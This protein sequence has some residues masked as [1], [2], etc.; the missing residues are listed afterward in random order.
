MRFISVEDI[1]Q[2]QYLGRTV[3]SSNGTVLLSSGV[4][5][6][7][8][9]INTLKRIGV[10]M[11]YI[12]DTDFEDIQMDEVLSESTKGQVFR[13]MNELH[14][15][16]RSGKE[17]STKKVFG[18]VDALLN[19][20]L[21]HKDVLLQLT[22]IRTADNAQ[23][24]HAVNVCLISSMIGLNMGLGFSQ[25]K[26]LAVGA[27]LHD[28]GK[29]IPLPEGADEDDMKNHHTWRGF[30]VLKHKREFNLLIAHTALQHHERMDGSGVPRGLM[31]E[32]IHL[33]PKIVAVA[34]RYDNLIGGGSEGTGRALLPHEACESLMASS[35]HEL[36]HEVLVEFTRIVSVYPNGTGVRLSTK[37][38]GVVVQQHRGLP[39]R[40]VIRIIRG[41][42]DDLDVKEIDLAVETTV[43]I[44]AVLA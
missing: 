4:Q 34:N 23:Y 24:L 8:Y 42:G 26:D 22:D 43:F 29:S 3:Y 36:D 40:P 13:E 28:M 35:E 9:M 44:E 21:N 33:Y 10:T 17:W 32:E 18:G 27:L 15:A 37:E 16:V 1:E 11:L 41:S 12:K 20:V 14:E 2:G 25:L 39:G 7:V 19:D 31:G 6:T 38:N 30:E 5:L